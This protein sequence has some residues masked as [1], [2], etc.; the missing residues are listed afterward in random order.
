MKPLFVLLGIFL[1]GVVGKLINGS[2]KMSYEWIGRLAM[3]VMLIFTGVAHFVYA[4]G[5]EAMLPDWVP[6][7]KLIVYLTG[8]FEFAGAVG[9]LLPGYYKAAGRWLIVFLI[10][11]VPANIYAAMH[12]IDPLTGGTDGHGPDYLFFRIPLQ[13][14]FI[15]WIYFSAIRLPSVRFGGT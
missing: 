4:A 2:K 11:V 6:F 14:F 13:L 9:L 7:R 8:F 3:A 1:L 5:M 12:H 15:L 10:A